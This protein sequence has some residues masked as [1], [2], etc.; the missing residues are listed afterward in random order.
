V[1]RAAFG[2]ALALAVALLLL[3]LA[4]A[5]CE[6]E[7]NMIQQDLPAARQTKARSDVLQIVRAVQTYQA[8]FGAL[9]GSL[10]ELTRAQSIGGVSGGPF[11]GSIPAPPAGWSPYQ[12]TKLAG[13][14]F[15]ITASGD[16][17]TVSAP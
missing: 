12:Y 3:S 1:S 4:L 6:R 10:H 7:Q 15:G 13:G 9:P 11:L 8:T 14:R 2:G 5:S 17:L 16:E